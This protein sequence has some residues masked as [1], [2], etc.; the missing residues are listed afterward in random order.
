[1]D[2]LAYSFHIGN[3]KN[4]SKKSKQTIKDGKVVDKVFN[5]NAIQN[6]NQ[7]SRANNHNLRKYDNNQDKIEIICGTNDLYEDVKKLY[8][9]EF[10]DARIKYNEKQTRNDRK[11]ENYFEHI[12]KNDKTDLACEII[13]ELGDMIFWKRKNEQYK[14]KMTNVFKEQINDLEKVVP[15]FKIANATIHYDESSPHLHIVGVP[16]KNGNKNGMEKQVGKSTIFTKESLRMIQDTMRIHCINSFNKIYNTNKKL[17]D[18][19]DGRGY[20]IASRDMDKKYGKLKRESDKNKQK[21]EKVNASTK[22]ILEKSMQV[23]DIVN[24]L[25]PTK[26]TKNNYLISDDDINTINEYIENVDSNVSEIKSVNDLTNIMEDFENA[27]NNHYDKIDELE[28]TIDEKDEKIQELES[29]IKDK[30]DIIQKKQTKIDNLNEDILKLNSTIS[31]LNE[32]IN[33]WKKT[34]KKLLNLILKKLLSFKERDSIYQDV[35]ID[36]QNEKILSKEDMSYLEKRY[37][38]KK[39]NPIDYDYHKNNYNYF[40][41]D[42]E[43]KEDDYEL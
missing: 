20:D 14:R 1:M 2:G 13:I 25:K 4:K 9:K 28:D 41:N 6:A 19:E 43:I 10:E 30:D 15:S 12:S 27:L 39:E 3:D 21:L 8:I 5:N 34:W 18:K 36:M 16:V 40:E 29:S 31:T 38:K 26:F 22:K 24:N 23:K 32:I 42:Y 33:S 37:D 17:K 7:L 35:V 11:I